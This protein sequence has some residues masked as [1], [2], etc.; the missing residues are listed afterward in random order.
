MK[1]T[2][3]LNLTNRITKYSALSLAIVGIADANGQ[4]VYTDLGP[5]GESPA[6]DTEYLLNF[7]NDDPP[8]PGAG[9]HEFGLKAWANG[10]GGS[11]L[12]L[13]VPPANAALGVV[14]SA[15]SALYPLD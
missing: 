14:G 12:M 2:T 3:P 4:I 6:F 15:Y 8:G 13:Y 10:Y 5:G 11:Q 9:V 1:K 7:N